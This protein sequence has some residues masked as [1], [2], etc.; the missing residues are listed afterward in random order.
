M[1]PRLMVCGRNTVEG[2]L[3]IDSGSSSPRGGTSVLSQQLSEFHCPQCG[4]AMDRGR[5]RC[6]WALLWPRAQPVCCRSE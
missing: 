1:S 4:L 3:V 6:C 5:P 2:V